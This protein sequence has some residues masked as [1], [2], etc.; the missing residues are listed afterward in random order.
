M[1]NMDVCMGFSKDKQNVVISWKMAGINYNQRLT[2][3]PSYSICRAIISS[4]HS[5]NEP[6]VIV[7]E[8]IADN[9]NRKYR[10]GRS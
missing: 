7:N 10:K 5:G 6:K 8:R 2:V 4:T 1:R 3:H 9:S